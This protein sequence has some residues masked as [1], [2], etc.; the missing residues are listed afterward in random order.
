VKKSLSVPK[1]DSIIIPV[2]KKHS[3]SVYNKQ[4]RVLVKN[5]KR[6]LR[7][8]AIGNFCPIFCTYMGEQKL[9]KSRKG[10]LS[11]PFRRDDSYVDELYLEIGHA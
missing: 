9:V 5:I 8:E 11:D 2:M 7:Q 3:I 4:T 1:I 10:D 6:K